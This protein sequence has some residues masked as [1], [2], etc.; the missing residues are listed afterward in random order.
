MAPALSR[1]HAELWCSLK[2]GIYVVLIKAKIQKSVFPLPTKKTT[3]KQN[4][5]HTTKGDQQI[6]SPFLPLPS[7]NQTLQTLLRGRYY[8]R[9]ITVAPR[10]GGVEI[11]HP[12]SGAQ[13]FLAK[14]PATIL[15]WPHHKYL[16]VKNNLAK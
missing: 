6:L 12:G 4:N 9:K 14:N 15:D 7:K 3:T 10:A 8:V 1:A 5:K 16:G 13:P 2:H 11:A